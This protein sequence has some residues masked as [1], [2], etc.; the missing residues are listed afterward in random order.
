MSMLNQF[1]NAIRSFVESANPKPNLCLMQD[2]LYVALWVDVKKSIPNLPD[3]I[4]PFFELDD[5]TVIATHG[6]AKQVLMAHWA[7]LEMHKKMSTLAAELVPLLVDEQAV[8]NGKS[9]DGG[10][11]LTVKSKHDDQG[12]KAAE[13]RIGRLVREMRKLL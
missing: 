6:T 13:R 9:V 11:P 12:G 1:R 10:D 7:P 4:P 2:D 3:E 5:C 8:S